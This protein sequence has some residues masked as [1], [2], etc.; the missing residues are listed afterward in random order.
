MNRIDG[1][2]LVF[3]KSTSSAARARYTTPR[4]LTGDAARAGASR[5][6]PPSLHE[7]S[8]PDASRRAA[9]PLL[10]TLFWNRAQM[11]LLL[12]APPTEGGGAR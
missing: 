8:R 11:S 7:S 3:G 4:A 5:S 10:P 1:L 12:P 9:L 2:R 6:E